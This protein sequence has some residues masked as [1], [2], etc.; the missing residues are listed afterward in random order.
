MA[1]VEL[2]PASKGGY[3]D[4]LGPRLAEE[5]LARGVLLRPLG[6]I[7]Y[8][9]PPLVITDGEVHGVFDVIEELIEGSG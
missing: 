1:A 5:A 3:L 8:M 6:N 7:L 4:A 9:L 2:H